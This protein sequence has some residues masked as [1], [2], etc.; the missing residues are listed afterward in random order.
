MFA[1]GIVTYE[2]LALRR[3]FQRNLTF[4]A[5][6]EQPIPDVRKYRPDVPSAVAE[7]IGKTLERDPDT[8]FEAAR[9][10]GTAI[11]DAIAGIKRAWTQGEIGDF[12]RDHFAAELS[13][14]AAEMQVSVG[15]KVT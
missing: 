2:M 1:L 8:R 10:F 12:V 7:L 9:Q 4:R 11:V 15:L 3:L 6:M 5:V 13:K 14:R